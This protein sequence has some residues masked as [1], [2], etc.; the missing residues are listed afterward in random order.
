MVDEICRHRAEVILAIAG[1]LRIKGMH[2]DEGFLH[3]EGKRA[4]YRIHLLS[5]AVHVMPGAHLCI[6]LDPAG[7]ED[8]VYLPFADTDAMISMILSKAL[9]LADDKAIR[10]PAI[11]SQLEALG[12]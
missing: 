3:V 8:D 9:M 4:S 10:D 12:N 2:W 11:L 1:T 6:I 5:A 7:K